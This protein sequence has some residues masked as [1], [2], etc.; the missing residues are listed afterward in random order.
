MGTKYEKKS[1]SIKEMEQRVK[2]W[3]DN[4]SISISVTS[5][6]NVS[7]NFVVKMS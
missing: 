2:T 1:T 7:I 4:T 5:S 6:E 3:E